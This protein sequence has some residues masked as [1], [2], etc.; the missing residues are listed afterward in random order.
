MIKQIP[1][2]PINLHD[3]VQLGV[4]VWSPEGL[5]DLSSIEFLPLKT[6]PR[7]IYNFNFEDDSNLIDDED[8]TGTQLDERLCTLE[9]GIVWS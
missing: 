7:P 3:S 5:V 9:N 4:S 6:K 8:K 2:V 1:I